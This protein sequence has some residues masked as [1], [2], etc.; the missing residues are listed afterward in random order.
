MPTFSRTLNDGSVQLTGRPDTQDDT[1]TQGTYEG[2]MD[3]KDDG[4]RSRSISQ[5]RQN[6]AGDQSQVSTPRV[7]FM[8]ADSITPARKAKKP[9][10]RN[11]KNRKYP[12][13]AD[14]GCQ[15]NTWEDFEPKVIKGEVPPQ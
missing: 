5:D 3:S 4:S 10:K 2:T 8:R 11:R 1:G 9:K 15:L 7:G 13:Y 12:G 14:N 6:T